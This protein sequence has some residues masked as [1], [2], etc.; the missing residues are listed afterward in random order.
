MRCDTCR[1]WHKR[2]DVSGH[3]HG[4]RIRFPVSGGPPV[5]VPMGDCRMMPPERHRLTNR[6]VFPLTLADDYCHVF[7]AKEI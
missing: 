7:V 6:G 1:Y 3:H 5:E 2:G 4:D